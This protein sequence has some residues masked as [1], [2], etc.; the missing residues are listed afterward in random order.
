MIDTVILL[1]PKEKMITPEN[2]P[3]SFPIWMMQNNGRGYSKWL[4]NMPEQKGTDSPYY[5]RLTKYITSDG[6][7]NIIEKIKIEFSAPKLIYGNNLDEVEE[8][9]FPAVIDTLQKRLLEMGEKVSKQDLACAAISTIHFSKNIPIS[10]GYTACDAMKEISKI[11]IYK[12]LS[13]T[14]VSYLNDGEA[15]HFYAASHSVVFYDKIA[16]LARK[17]KAIDQDQTARHFS[18]ANDIKERMPSLEILRMEIRLC[19]KRKINSVMT[20]TGFQRNPTFKDVFK[21]DLCQK[22]IR[23]YWD[24]LIAG[25]NLFLFELENNPKK[26]LKKLIRINPKLKAK[27]IIYLV[28]LQALCRDD[29]GIRELRSIL[30][31]RITQHSWYR[32][33]NGIKLLNHIVDKKFLCGWVKQIDSAIYNFEPFKASLR[34]P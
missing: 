31:K 8:S 29:G 23:W 4:K 17:K 6:G 3:D 12:K 1:M 16:D 9:H 2:N 11:N 5:P 32:I 25:E 13:L 15:L 28:G 26:L 14:K 21:K 34:P 24:A 27:E 19:K 33:V 18:L 7:T 30:E 10:N 20:K 22:I